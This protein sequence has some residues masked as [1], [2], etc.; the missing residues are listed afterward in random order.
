LARC[1][2]DILVSLGRFFEL[3]EQSPL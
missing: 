1:P 3:S 2:V